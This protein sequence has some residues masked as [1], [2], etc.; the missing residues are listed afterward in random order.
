LQQYND[1]LQSQLEQG[2]VEKVLE[3]DVDNNFIKPYLPHHLVV[4]P[5]ETLLRSV[6]FM[7]PLS[8]LER[9]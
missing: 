5:P 1:I 2:I 7:M 6:L 8:S 9:M 3:A 4:K